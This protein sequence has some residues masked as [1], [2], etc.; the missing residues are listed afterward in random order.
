MK[1][2]CFKQNFSSLFL[3]DY[4]YS[5][6]FDEEPKAPE[7]E[8]VDLLPMSP[9]D[10]DEEKYRSAPSTLLRKCVRERK[11]SKILTPSKL[12]TIK[13]IKN[14]IDHLLHKYKRYS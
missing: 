5:N 13:K 11:G 8:L 1:S 12:L 7:V 10:G 2:N 4:E 6:Y 3:D 9:L 14:E